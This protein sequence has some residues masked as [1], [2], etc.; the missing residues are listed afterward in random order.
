MHL[1]F[2]ALFQ[3]SSN[4]L[5]YLSRWM[6]R[7]PPAGVRAWDGASIDSVL[8][9]VDS[10]PVDSS[11]SETDSLLAAVRRFGVPLE[12]TDSETIRR[13]HG[14]FIREGLDLR[15]T[16]TG[17]SPRFFYP[18]L[19]ELILQ[20]DLQGNRAN[21]LAT[22]AA[23]RFLKDLQ[24]RDRVIPVVGDLAG[25]R[26]FPAVGREVAARGERVSALY[27]SNVEMYIWRDGTFRNF[28]S[29]AARFP[30]RENSVIIRSFFGGG[31][32][33]SHPLKQPDHFST[34]LVQTLDDFARREAGGWSS[35][36]SLVTLGN[37]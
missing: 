31:F 19:R 28:A 23:W 1:M 13:F 36:W 24:A 12:A 14:T 25:T 30:R 2:K 5:E 20:R 27:V 18:T 34:Q 9:L 26:A 37:R 22:E 33:Q 4:R 8:A 29:N 21:Y 7:V 10:L 32:G 17:R 11:L 3:R 16:S 35:Y 15:F 6:G